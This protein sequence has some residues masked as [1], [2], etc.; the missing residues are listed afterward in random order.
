MYLQPLFT[1]VGSLF[2]LHQTFQFLTE[3]GSQNIPSRFFDA[4]L[5]YFQIWI[6][7]VEKCFIFSRVIYHPDW[8]FW[9]YKT[10]MDWFY[11]GNSTKYMPLGVRV[12]NSHQNVWTTCKTYLQISTLTQMGKM[13]IC[14]KSK[15]WEESPLPLSPLESKISVLKK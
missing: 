14:K 3:S 4:V 10:N 12:D 2:G 1:V 11:S 9:N 15:P 8:C 7:F 6:N 5:L 13:L